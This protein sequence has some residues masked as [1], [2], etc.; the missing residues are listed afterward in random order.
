MDD[1]RE[2]APT[3]SDHPDLLSLVTIQEIRPS[4]SIKGNLDNIEV[5]E[6]ITKHVLEG[7][8][9]EDT[10]ELL[11]TLAKLTAKARGICWH[12]NVCHNFEGYPWRASFLNDKRFFPA[13]AILV[14]EAVRRNVQDGCFRRIVGPI[15]ECNL[16]VILAIGIHDQFYFKPDSLK[17]DVL[18]NM[19]G[20]SRYDGFWIRFVQSDTPRAFIESIKNNPPPNLG[21][22]IC[23]LAQIIDREYGGD[24]LQSFLEQCSSTEEEDPEYNLARNMRKRGEH[25]WVKRALANAKAKTQRRIGKTLPGV[26]VDVEG[27][28]L[29]NQPLAN[30]I[31]HL[32]NQGASVTV[33]TDGDTEKLSQ[34][35]LAD[36]IDTRV[37]P[38]QSKGQYNGKNLEILIDDTPTRYQ[39]FIANEVIV[40]YYTPQGE[41]APV[42][43]FASPD[44]LLGSL[45]QRYGYPANPEAG[46]SQADAESH[47]PAARNLFFSLRRLICG[48]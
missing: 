27:T 36:G 7:P 23:A 12:H 29:D 6:H 26:F 22:R 32:L 3:A 38:V 24:A 10:P 41:S 9:G 46:K 47:H 5:L 30:Y 21:G 39:G 25:E 35:L 43:T 16:D 8:I 2:A 13:A 45:K 28:L 44:N 18:Q 1:H 33:F 34:R 14:D 19:D 15:A 17:C 31:I 11:Q 42:N 37:L 20:N 40:P 4:L 48:G